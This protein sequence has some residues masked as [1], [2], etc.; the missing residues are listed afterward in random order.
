MSDKLNFLV[1]ATGKP[2]R[3]LVD[4]ISK[5]GH[6][7]EHHN[8]DGLY[9]FI[10]ESE[11]GY[12]RI[13]NGSSELESPVRLKAK[14]FNAIISRIGSNLNH[15]ATILRHLTDNIGIYCPQDADGLET[16]SNKL[17][18]TQRLSTEGLRVPPTTYASN[19][20][21]IDFLI[22]KV[23]GLPAIGK[24]IN[25]SQGVGVFILETPQAANTTLESLFKLK[26]NIKIQKFVKAG[27]KDIR[28]I[29]VGD[30]V[31]VAM[32]RTGK[33]DFR[34]NISQGGSGRKVELSE[35]DIAICVRAARAV[36][37]DF[38]G[39][40]IIKD[41]EGKTYVVE[42][43][44]NPG[45]KIITITGHNYFDDLVKYVESKVR[46]RRKADL[47]DATCDSTDKS[48]DEVQGSWVS[49]PWNQ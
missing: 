33:K 12:D 16:A 39:V 43:N 7:L 46:G 2:S 15:G 26:A 4:A 28:A 44:G 45:S 17:K 5:H 40:D 47:T 27:S 49:A 30:Q 13:Y 23:G 20:L 14:S 8:P 42:V 25:G 29:V 24:L 9:L 36:N 32:E 1:L 41:E 11:S 10:S 18:T 38:A 48:T 35:S 37:L 21:H 6:T 3:Y 34:A 19:P 22:N 31:V